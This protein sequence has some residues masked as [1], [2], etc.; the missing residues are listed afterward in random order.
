VNANQLAHQA[1]GSASLRSP[2]QAEYQV[3]STVTARLGTAN[4][5]GDF[6]CLAGALHDN[7]RLWTRLAADVADP[8][9]GLPQE[10]RARI[11]YLAEFTRA[12]TRRVLKG[13]AK[14]QALI[15]INTAI[16]RGLSG[17]APA[18]P[19]MTAAATAPSNLAAAPAA[20]AHRVA[21]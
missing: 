17:T 11:F 20:L 6:P 1:Y 14:A 21:P 9:N 8:N 7:G 10:L 3:L 13:E 15:D 4:T 5:Q 2:R 19:P 16:M 12:H 18:A